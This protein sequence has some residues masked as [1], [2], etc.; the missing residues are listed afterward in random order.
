ML[1]IFAG[2]KLWQI[3]LTAVF[4]AVWLVFIVLDCRRKSKL[5]KLRRERE[6]ILKS[7]GYSDEQ[8]KKLLSDPKFLSLLAQQRTNEL[9]LY[10]G[11]S[12]SGMS[13]IAGSE[14]SKDGE[15]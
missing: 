1:E 3:I 12:G 9:N 6:K 5:K 13:R 4:G 10:C 14:I 8:I 2:W 11:K 7:R 15:K